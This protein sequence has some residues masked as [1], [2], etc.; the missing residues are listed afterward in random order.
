M[1]GA[2]FIVRP[3]EGEDKGSWDYRYEMVDLQS[4]MTWYDGGEPEDN[5]FS[6]DWSWVPD[7]CNELASEIDAL[8]AELTELRRIG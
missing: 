2:R 7:L 8:K 5:S 3:I 4:G 6:R 1:P